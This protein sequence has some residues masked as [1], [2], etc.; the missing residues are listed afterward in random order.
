MSWAATIKV[1]LA[2]PTQLE[3]AAQLG[4]CRMVE[5]ILKKDS[6]EKKLNLQRP[7]E[8]ATAHGHQDILDLLI[9]KGASVSSALP[10]AAK[11]NDTKLLSHLLDIKAEPE[12]KL[13]PSDLVKGLN[14]AARNG[15]LESLQLILA[16]AKEIE[17]FN[18]LESLPLEEAAKSGHNEMLSHILQYLT[19]PDSTADTAYDIS[20]IVEKKVR[21]AF[22]GACKQG[23]GMS[24]SIL[25]KS[26]FTVK[27]EDLSVAVEAGSLNLVNSILQ[28][29][30]SQASDGTVDS[31]HDSNALLVAAERGHMDIIELLRQ[32]GFPINIKS[33]NWDTVLHKAALQGNLELTKYLIREAAD[34]NVEIKVPNHENMTPGQFAAKEGN[35]LL[36]ETLQK[37]PQ[38]AS[39]GDIISAAEN[40][41]LRMVRYL[42]GLVRMQ[43]DG[44]N[45]Q[46]ERALA[47]A[48]SRGYLPVIRV[49]RQEGVEV[50]CQTGVHSVLHLAASNGHIQVVE[51][52]ISEGAHPNVTRQ[53][54]RTPLHESVA[55][56]VI[57]E[58][59]LDKK[60]DLEAIDM[61]NRTP[62]HFAVA[63]KKTIDIDTL[64]TSIETLLKAGANANAMDESN[65]TPIHI[66]A[67]LSFLRAASLLLKYSA[68]S[69]LI[70]KSM[71]TSLRTAVKRN[72]LAL[73]QVILESNKDSCEVSGSD[74]KTPLHIAVQEGDMPILR[75]VLDANSQ[76]VNLK[77]EDG[78]TPFG[79]AADREN[80]D[81]LSVLFDAGVDI[82]SADA[83]QITALYRAS[84]D[85]RLKTVKLLVEKG[86]NLLLANETGLTPLNIAAALG[87]LEVR[88]FS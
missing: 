1:L 12:C 48:A 4:L 84:R 47:T 74:G 38:D 67:E 26:N 40:G 82:N 16:Y 50:N 44:G 39:Y 76:V 62:L 61:E 68:Q 43:T 33:E 65:N 58:R 78:R 56:L 6:L 87:E 53:F 77:D 46:L 60:A 57:M 19:C 7:L 22:V 86:A 8:L 23:E 79:Y 85:S 10:A 81:N 35:L 27:R 37:N 3:I 88:F 52:L 69:T 11:R 42:L 18:L 55:H 63:S 29:A 64:E 28:K 70:N 34:G 20:D 2:A 9:Q 71:A 32:E 45:V 36:S 80:T 13:D 21:D 25:L 49:L 14:A 5:Q 30:R 54:G 51:Y 72:Y 66:A 73:V 41:Q 83:K 59:L 24:A 75:L 15:N 31:L 17:G